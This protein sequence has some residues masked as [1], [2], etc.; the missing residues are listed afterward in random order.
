M[1]YA[2]FMLCY[3]SIKDFFLFFFGLVNNWREKITNP[4]VD[5]LGHKYIFF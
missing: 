4:S 1:Q 3:V 2:L 5:T